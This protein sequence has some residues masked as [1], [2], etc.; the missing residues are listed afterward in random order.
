MGNAF[1]RNWKKLTGVR[2]ADADNSDDVTDLEDIQGEIA[3]IPPPVS[4]SLASVLSTGNETDGQGIVIS[5]FGD[6]IVGKDGDTSSAVRVRLAGGG[7]GGS[8]PNA[9]DAI[10]VGGDA[11]GGGQG[12]DVFVQG[13]LG[14]DSSGNAGGVIMAGGDA[15]STGGG[16]NIQMT[17]GE[18]IGGTGGSVILNPG[19]SFGGADGNVQIGNSL[20]DVAIGNSGGTTTV[21]GIFKLGTVS[22]LT[23]TGS[24]EGVVT[25]TVGSTFHRTDGGASTT[26]YVKESGAGNTGWVAK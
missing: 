4:Q 16:G 18:G 22:L 17:G 10:V 14:G 8:F 24:P 23:G 7:G 11:V 26:L 9:A 6:D 15:Q 20:G 19:S 2:S 25:A 13:G 3:A 1:K 21:T 5:S 12:G